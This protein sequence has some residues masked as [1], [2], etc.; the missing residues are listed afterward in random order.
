[1]TAHDFKKILKLLQRKDALQARIASID[2]A[3]A[4]Y[5]TGEPAGPARRKPG[6]KPGPVAGPKPGRGGRRG[7]TKAAIIELV[8][9]AGKAGITV[10]EVAAKLR[11]PTQR[12]YVWFFATGK[13]V[14]EIKKVGKAKYAWIG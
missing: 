9:R 10:K 14:K 13:N 6:R 11:V 3:L 12:V 2:S 5:E 7:S 8:K 4:C 1:M